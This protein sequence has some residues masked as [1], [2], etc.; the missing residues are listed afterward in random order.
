MGNQKDR[1]LRG[2]A[3][4]GKVRAFAV[5]TTDLVEELR[6]RHDT[7]PVVTAALGRTVSAAAMMG[8]MLKGDERLSIQVRGDGP[9][10]LIAAESNAKGEVRGYVK[11]PHVELTNIRPG[12]MDV[13]AAVGTTG[14][15]DVVKDFGL[16]EPYR[17]SVPIISGEL[18]EDFTYYFA[19]SEQTNSAVSLGVL[20]SPD[21]SVANAGGFIIQLLP[22]VSDEEITEIELALS[23]IPPITEML[24]EGLDLEDILKRVVPDV[25]ILEETEVYFSCDCSHERV[26]RAL[27]SLGREELEQMIEEDGKAEVS[28]HFCNERYTFDREQLKSVL[29]RAKS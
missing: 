13:A 4:N 24:E 19:V 9:I 26:E 17:G 10:G 1:M 7:F 15:I 11:N 23:K 21:Y 28:C 20:V 18:A 5:R 25:T 16:K 2:T 3:L 29:E 8:A 14:Q 27:I 12:K 22:G 6:R